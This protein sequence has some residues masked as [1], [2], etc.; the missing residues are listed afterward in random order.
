MSLS[1]TLFCKIDLSFPG[2]KQQAKNVDLSNL[3]REKERVR[4]ER[5][6]E[7]ERAKSCPSSNLKLIAVV[8][9]KHFELQLFVEL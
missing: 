9:F 7:R 4:R 3:Q 2:E 1:V 6:R 5:E 8:N